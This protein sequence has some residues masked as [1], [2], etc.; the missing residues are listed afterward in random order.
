LIIS[1]TV[2]V[3][4]GLHDH[5]REARAGGFVPTSSMKE[6]A[7]RIGRAEGL[8]ESVLAYDGRGEPQRL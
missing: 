5:G 8:A 1:F 2:S 6:A 4:F 3:A 7:M